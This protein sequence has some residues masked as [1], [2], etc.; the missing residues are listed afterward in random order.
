M[1]DSS[2]TN[3]V[4]QKLNIK[5]NDLY[6]VVYRDVLVDTMDALEVLMRIGKNR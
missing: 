5:A 4:T 2:F 3:S 6:I 1:A